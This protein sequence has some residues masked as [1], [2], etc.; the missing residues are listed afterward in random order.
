MKKC[1]A[2]Y[3]YYILKIAMIVVIKTLFK[4]YSFDIKVEISNLC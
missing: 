3:L 2:S 1:Q 4:I